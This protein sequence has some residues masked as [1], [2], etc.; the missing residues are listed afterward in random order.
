MNRVA[1]DRG[2]GAEDVVDIVNVSSGSEAAIGA[3]VAKLLLG[4]GEIGVTLRWVGLGSRLGLLV[5]DMVEVSVVTGY[6]RKVYVE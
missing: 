1:L 3:R 5:S 6:G 4:G 2:P